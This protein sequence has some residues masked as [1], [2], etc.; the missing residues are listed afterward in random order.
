MSSLH[1]AVQARAGDSFM[2]IGPVTVDRQNPPKTAKNGRLFST[3]T[4]RSASGELG[5][6]LWDD[7]AKWKL[8]L[9]ELTLK[10][11]FVKN[12]IQKLDCNELVPPDGAEEYRDDQ[13]KGPVEVASMK[14]CL[15]AGIRGADY[16]IKCKRPEL[17]QAAFAFAAQA[18]SQGV[19][20]E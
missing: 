3:V 8:P 17:A 15:D 9:T 13:I 10:G 18:L 12:N 4:L 6:F 20:L 7:A 14:S 11:K 16:V 5:L 2:L 1:E 19:R